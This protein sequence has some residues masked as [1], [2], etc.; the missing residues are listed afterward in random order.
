MGGERYLGLGEKPQTS[1][2]GRKAKYWQLLRKK[3]GEFSFRREDCV[4]VTDEWKSLLWGGS[5]QERGDRS[6]EVIRNCYDCEQKFAWLGNYSTEI[7]R[8]SPEQSVG[9]GEGTGS[10]NPLT[11]RRALPRTN[12]QAASYGACEGEDALRRAGGWE[13]GAPGA[14]GGGT[15]GGKEGPGRQVREDKKERGRGRKTL[16]HGR[17]TQGRW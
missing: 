16:V 13:R 8:N 14:A 6:H 15:W 17:A 1:N 12:F 3:R 10:E 5:G 9:G 4:K 7:T 2:G 11:E